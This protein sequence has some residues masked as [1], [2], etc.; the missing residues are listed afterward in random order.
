MLRPNK[1]LNLSLFSAF[2]LRILYFKIK[3]IPVGASSELHF[4]LEINQYWYKEM[5]NIMLNPTS[6]LV[7]FFSAR[8]HCVWVCFRLV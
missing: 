7:P 6:T 1:K 2:I 3:K 5:Q 8:C 4:V